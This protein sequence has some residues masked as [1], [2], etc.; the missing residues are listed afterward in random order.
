MPSKLIDW[1][2]D[3]VLVSCML[4]KQIGIWP[5]FLSNLQNMVAGH[6]WCN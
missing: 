6:R 1:P 4:M 3:Y 5:S 2:L